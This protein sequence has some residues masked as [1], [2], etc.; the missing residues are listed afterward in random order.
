MV[1]DSHDTREK[2]GI[3]QLPN[4]VIKLVETM[5]AIDPHFSL[6]KWLDLKA[7]D[8]LNLIQSD[9]EREKIQLE[10]R[11]HRLDSIA[12]RLNPMDIRE[13]PKG[14]TNLFDCFDLPEPFKHMAERIDD[15]DEPHPAGTFTNLLPNDDCDDPLMAVTAQM[16]LIII[17]EK[18]AKG[19]TWVELGEIYEPLLQNEISPEECDEALDHLLMSGQVHEIDDDCFILDE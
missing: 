10:Q 9:I 15:Y 6:E 7:K 17:Q 3:E 5:L 14:Q 2:F 19:S 11:M 8:E 18:L 12:K 1:D 4:S 16:M 13:V